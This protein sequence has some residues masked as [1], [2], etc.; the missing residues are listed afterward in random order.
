MRLNESDLESIQRWCARVRQAAPEQAREML[1]PLRHLVYDK[2]PPQVTQA[3][4]DAL[5]YGI[6]GVQPGQAAQ[7][8]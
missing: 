2:L 3:V 8:N 6:L 4:E 5:H 1:N 7:L